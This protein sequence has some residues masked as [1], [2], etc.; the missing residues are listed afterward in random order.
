MSPGKERDVSKDAVLEE[1]IGEWRSY[2]KRRQA[3][4][5]VDVEEL[6]DHL[7]NQVEALT[8]MGL[9]EDEAFLVAVKRLGDMDSVSREFASEYSE[10]LWKQLVV[11]PA[12]EATAGA[13]RETAAAIGLAIGR[14]LDQ[15]AR[16]L[17]RAVCRSQRAV[18]SA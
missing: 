8:Q 5:A 1:R 10:R 3:V 7:R 12:A 14:H 11:T 2:F 6:E 17:R 9:A 16:A 18:L 15:A 13:H 4:H